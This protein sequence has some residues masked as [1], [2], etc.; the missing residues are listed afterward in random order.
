MCCRGICDRTKPANWG[1]VSIFEDFQNE[2]ELI[3]YLVT[4]I[5]IFI[6]NL[7]WKTLWLIP[8]TQ[9]QT[10]SVSYE[11]VNTTEHLAAKEADI[12]PQELVETNN[13][14]RR[15][16]SIS[17]PL[18]RWCLRSNADV[19]CWMCKQATVCKHVHHVKLPAKE[20]AR[21]HM[22]H[23]MRIHQYGRLNVTFSLL[24][25]NSTIL[26]SHWSVFYR[27]WG[28]LL[29]KWNV[30]WWVCIKRCI[31]GNVV[32]KRFLWFWSFVF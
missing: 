28:V 19:A 7:H 12:P 23:L 30:I 29:H 20:W 26:C 6:W 8:C 4:Y 27:P 14:A 18:A 24:K 1:K 31:V 25:G 11:Q 21:D 9:T 16:A 10:Q 17:L 3:F 13:A 15:R 5:F 22:W 2:T 32:L